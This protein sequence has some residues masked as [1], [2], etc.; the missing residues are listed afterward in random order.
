MAAVVPVQADQVKAGADNFPRGRIVSFEAGVLKFRTPDN[1]LHLIPITAVDQ[2]A[3]ISSA[4]AKCKASPPTL[5]PI[6][7]TSTAT[8]V[9]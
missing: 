4:F 1:E 9:V 6:T 3:N 8:C 7:T 2:N 5:R